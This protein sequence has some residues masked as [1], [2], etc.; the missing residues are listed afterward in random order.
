M[1]TPHQRFRHADIIESL[2]VRKDKITGEYYSRV[3]D[4]QETFPGAVRF[5]VNGVV[6]N[7]LEDENELRYE[8]RRI[9]H[10]PNDVIDIVI[11]IA[12]RMPLS[13]PIS[14][15]K[16]T[17]RTHRQTPQSPPNGN[18][19]YAVSFLSLQSTPT[20]FSSDL[21]RLPGSA[22]TMTASK[23]LLAG[24]AA[25]L[26]LNT[27]GILDLQ[28]QF[29][30]LD[31]TGSVQH[32]QLLTQITQ[33]MHYQNELLE[34]Q[35]EMLQ[36]QADA[37]AR[38]EKV[39][40][41][42]EAAKE[43]DL[44]THRLQKQTIDRLIVAQQRVDAIL[45]QN[46]ELHEYP[47][48]RLFVIL[49]DSYESWDPRN[50]LKERFRLF[51]LCE[52]GEDCGS[53]TSHG[54]TSSQL[55]ITAPDTPV[56]PI[57]VRNRIHLAKH[58]G[59]ELS[60]PT[61]FFDRYGSYVLGMLKI[62]KHCLAVATVVAPVVALVDGG[63]KDVMDGVKSIS[64]STMEA[65][66]ISINFLEQELDDGGV[67]DAFAETGSD[68]QDADNMFEN[69]AA[70]EGAD[71]R[72]L[73]TFL[74]NNDQDKILGN[75]YRTTTEEGHVK[76]VCF[77]HYQEKYQ[78]TALASFVQSVEAA[79]GT[80]DPHFR[81]VTISLT[82]STVA[83][84]FFMRL[85]RQ[86]PVVDN[87][88][89]TL[90]WDFGSADLVNLV[91]MVAKSNVRSITL[92]LQDDPTSKSALASFRPGKGRYH[93]L[94]SLFSNKNI[95]RL[96]LSNLHQLGTRTSNLPSSVVAP[97]MQSFHFH[98][99]V[100]DEGRDRLTNILSRCP[101][102]VDLRLTGSLSEGNIMDPSLHLQIFGLKKLQRLHVTGWYQYWPETP[103]GYIWKD[104]MSL[105][106]LVCTTGTLERNFVG[107]SIQRSGKILEVLVL[108]DRYADNT[109]IILTPKIIGEFFDGSYFSRLTHLELQAQLANGSLEFLSSTLPRL[110]LVHFGCDWRTDSLLRH[111][112]LASLKS[113]AVG[114]I[115]NN[116]WLLRGA[117]QGLGGE[118]QI[119]SLNVDGFDY[120]YD[121]LAK[122]LDILRLKRLFLSR[123]SASAM[124]YLFRHANLSSLQIISLYGSEYLP[125]VE[126]V[127]AQRRKDE[128]AES[129]VVQLDVYS[130]NSYANASVG[131]ATRA[132]TQRASPSLPL[133]HCVKDLR[134][135]SDHS[136]QFLQPILPRYSY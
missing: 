128:F 101:S 17:E 90:A 63:V 122:I 39:L 132:Q 54:T 110:N 88:D 1:T 133:G 67:S 134:S 45:V 130:W 34:K 127:L 29:A 37:K 62:L 41:E 79:N 78:A 99:Q 94:L 117:I 48:P 36:E 118:C 35:N 104:G 120:F 86:A 40:A 108:V 6:L 116:F 77:E 31:N 103:G 51:F 112:N 83:K 61:E 16:K 7:F 66:D 64:E 20:S 111:I 96:Q 121:D 124:V 107:G 26:A 87:L 70:L 97:W 9:A 2:A 73:D 102:L 100:N 4:I 123:A 129:F 131:G 56:S 46:Y 21:V 105:Q 119:E 58:E 80:Y 53:E 71:L 30:Q 24:L 23:P 95:R 12:T 91:N 85:A 92:D 38:D 47:I 135:L 32:Q 115:S 43:R 3:I 52:C 25:T 76:W 69:L 65:V 106:E 89:V 82:S 74:Q 81:R 14:S 13:S 75:L 49:P 114:N 27:S 33:M 28:Q 125:E 22:N 93:S 19:D 59:Y 10:H 18:I 60:R 5:K 44:E 98:G 8:P 55:A 113:L 68:G 42:F 84:D 11:A 126:N 72:R 136:L 57:R 15:S 50:F 109:P